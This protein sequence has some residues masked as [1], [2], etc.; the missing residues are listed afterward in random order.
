MKDQFYMAR[1]SVV[2]SLP[3]STRKCFKEGS[4]QTGRWDLCWTM[5]NKMEII[6]EETDIQGFRLTN[7]QKTK[8]RRKGFTVNER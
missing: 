5:K 6:L 3:G 1:H 7:R 4:S 2:S 8:R